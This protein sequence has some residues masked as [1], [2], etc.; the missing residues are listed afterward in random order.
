M[1]ES[2]FLR[3]GEPL[4]QQRIEIEHLM[5]RLVEDLLREQVFD[6]GREVV[7]L[8]TLTPAAIDVIK[9]PFEGPQPADQAVSR[10]VIQAIPANGLDHLLN[11]CRAALAAAFLAISSCAKS[12]PGSSGMT[13]PSKGHRYLVMAGLDPAIHR[14]GRRVC[15]SSWMAGSSPAMTRKLD[16]VP[17]SKTASLRLEDGEAFVRIEDVA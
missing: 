5:R 12:C 11:R 9:H 13:R 1:P 7:D 15:R 4:A 17:A 14:S 8:E 6:R 10:T 2:V 16:R 3:G